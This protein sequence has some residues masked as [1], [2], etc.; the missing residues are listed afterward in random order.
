MKKYRWN[1]KKFIGTLAAMALILGCN[2]LV[3]WM[4]VTWVLTA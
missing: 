1:V 3:F 2:V 4:L